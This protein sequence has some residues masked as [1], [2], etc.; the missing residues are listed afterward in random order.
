[1]I[2]RS[3]PRT[4]GSSLLP[5]TEEQL[6][7]PFGR[8]E[9]SADEA[10][11]RRKTTIWFAVAVLITSFVGVLSWRSTRWA[12][13]E[14]DLIAHTH[15][16][17]TTLE[18]TDKHVLEVE[19]SARMFGMTAQA[20]LLSH[21]Q[22]ARDAVARNEY[23]LRHLTAGNSNQQRR[24]DE[25]EPQIQATLEFS[26]R[27]VARRQ[28]M[29]IGPEVGEFME[30]E[31]LM[32]TVRATIEEMQAVEA[33]LL[34]ELARKTRS[35]RR[36]TISVIVL[37][38]LLGAGF[39]IVAGFA[40]NRQIEVS[41]RARVQIIAL[42]ADLEQRVAQRTAALWAEVEE[43]A[44][45]TE[46]L[47][48]SEEWFRLLL[49]G[50][51]DYAVYMLDPEGR[52]ISWNAGA[53]RIKGY[54]AEE[55][56]GKNFSCFYT[57]ADQKSRKPQRALKKALAEG[58]CEDEGNRVRRDGSVIWASIVLRPMYDS[59]GA[60]RG[61]SKVARD[62]T[63]RKQA[64]EKLAGQ[65]KNL[66]GQSQ[67]LI[68]SQQ[69]IQLLNNG[70]EQRVVERTAQLEASNKELEAF[71]YS[72]SHDLRA[73]LRHIGGFAKLLLEE[74][75]PSLPPGA[76]KHVERM[77]EGARK[78][79]Q[80]IDE[81]LGLARVGRQ[82]LS[83]QVTGLGSIVKDVLTLLTPESEGRQVEW[84]IAADLPYVECDPGLVRQVFQNLI[85]NALKY[86]RPRSPAV[87]EIGKF[88]KDGQAVIFVRDNG[89]GFSM[90][91]ADKLFG[92]FQRL[93]RA[94]DFEGTG[95]G[96]ATVQRIIQKHGGRIWANAEIDGGATFYFTLGGVNHSEAKNAA[97][98][99][100]G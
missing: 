83:V 90:K 48:V 64:E 34:D 60:L 24:L 1:M 56:L 84:K 27:M 78:M 71:T 6:P 89:V 44:E 40:V 18:V 97:A 46:L 69:E 9:P 93:H 96:L 11:L 94:E 29:H 57:A 95:V 53:A 19:T 10:L 59:S 8:P 99:A 45:S 85:D 80:L 61:Y 66:L 81:L 41:A 76:Q 72:V 70:L 67:E 79:G 28:K 39:L 87:I 31:R 5:L 50:I 23:A 86:S 55:I 17:M 68:R 38:S 100:G 63:E 91:Y 37:G 12:G 73:P 51:K 26:D 35:A 22:S 25:L 62:I 21:Y 54:Q 75:G 33:G 30:A 2:D 43:H 16:V 52:V 7:G 36:L 13:N 4:A 92:V 32:D 20:A 98:S 3:D 74:S 47:R 15:A 88:E 42:S 49:D 65:A 77:E 82:A 14:S 58:R